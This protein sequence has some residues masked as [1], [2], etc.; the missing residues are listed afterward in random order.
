MQIDLR[1]KA[2]IKQMCVKIIK[3]YICVHYELS[4][5][6]LGVTSFL[7]RHVICL[8][9]KF[10][11]E[12]MSQFLSGKHVATIFFPVVDFVFC[13]VVARVLISNLVHFAWS[14][15]L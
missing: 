1:I 2:I 8:G 6:K 13:S 10:P 11:H 14:I 9:R 3:K 5:M 4:V 7:A 12:Q 15:S